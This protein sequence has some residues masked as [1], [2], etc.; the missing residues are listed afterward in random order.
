VNV[1]LTL[2]LLLQDKPKL[3]EQAKQTREGLK[4]KAAQWIAVHEIQQ[5]Q[6]EIYVLQAAGR[7][8]FTIAL[9]TAKIVIIERDGFWYVDAGPNDRKKYRP[10]E[11]PLPIPSLYLYLARSELRFA[12]AILADAKFS[13]AEA[14]EAYYKVPLTEAQREFAKNHIKQ[15]SKMIQ[16]DPARFKARIG[17]ALEQLQLALEEGMEV[18][19]QVENGIISAFAENQSITRIT[20]FAYLDKV[21]DKEFDVG[22]SKWEDQASDIS[23]G[24]LV[25]FIH[26]GAW[27]AGSPNRDSDAAIYDI[28]TGAVRRVP[29]RGGLCA[30]GCF[31]KDRSKVVVSGMTP[32]GMALFEID[33]KTGANRPIAHRTL[34]GGNVMGPVLSN[35]GKKLAA[36]QTGMTEQPLEFSLVVIDLATDQ[37]QRIGK[38][39]DQAFISWLPDDKGFIAIRRESK[40]MDSVSTDTIVRVDLDGKIVDVRKGSHPLLL[41]DG[42]TILFEDDKVWKTC[43]LEGKNESIFVDGLKG[44]GFPTPAPDGK[45]ILFIRFKQGDAPRPMVVRIDEKKIEPLH[46]LPGLWSAPEWR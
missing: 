29:F 9:G 4:N 27:V 8:R 2:L 18:G 35:D 21:E 13:S 14:G 22:T 44:H 30:P 7:R 24:D 38:P 17:P 37:I 39:R 31:M 42:R 40:D 26:N 28:K 25:M 10:Y 12:D 41:R 32:G 19:V 5:A 20:E 11:A 23:Q 36:I 6:I 16:D 46:Q 3:I 1:I 33:L 34:V 15:F 45:R 43:D